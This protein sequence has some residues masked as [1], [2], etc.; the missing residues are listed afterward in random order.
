MK[1][2]RITDPVTCSP[3]DVVEVILETP[4]GLSPS[5]HADDSVSTVLSILSDRVNDTSDVVQERYETPQSPTVNSPSADE[6]ILPSSEEASEHF[7]ATLNFT[8]CPPLA[9]DYFPDFEKQTCHV[10]GNLIAF[11]GECQSNAGKTVHTLR[12]AVLQEQADETTPYRLGVFAYYTSETRIISSKVIEATIPHVLLL[13]EGGELAVVRVSD[14][15]DLKASSVVEMETIALKIAETK[16][17]FKMEKAFSITFD[18]SI[19]PIA[20]DWFPIPGWSFATFHRDFFVT[21]QMH[22]LSSTNRRRATIKFQNEYDVS[23][24]AEMCQYSFCRRLARSCE[25]VET[26]KYVIAKREI[27]VETTTREGKPESESESAFTSMKGLPYVDHHIRVWDNTLWI[28]ILFAPHVMGV[29]RDRVGCVREPLPHLQGVVLFT[30]AELN[31]S[32]L[33]SIASFPDPVPQINA[34]EFHLIKHGQTLSIKS[35]PQHLPPYS[36]A[37]K[38]CLFTNNCTAIILH[39]ATCPKMPIKQAMADPVFVQTTG[40]TVLKFVNEEDEAPL[41]CSVPIN[42]GDGV[43][44][45]ATC[46]RVVDDNPKLAPLLATLKATHKLSSPLQAFWTYAILIRPRGRGDKSALSMT[47]R[48]T[49][50]DPFLRNLEPMSPKRLPTDDPVIGKPFVGTAYGL[51][52]QTSDSKQHVC[53]LKLV[54]QCKDSESVTE[55]IALLPTDSEPDSDGLRYYAALK[56]NSFMPS[57][58][59]SLNNVDQTAENNA[60][61]ASQSPCDAPS[62][63]GLAM[64][65]AADFG[66]EAD[67]VTAEGQAALSRPSMTP[68]SGPLPEVLADGSHD[69]QT[70]ELD[71]P[72]DPIPSPPGFSS[73]LKRPCSAGALP[74]CHIREEPPASRD[75]SAET[76]NRLA[77]AIAAETRKVIKEDIQEVVEKCVRETVTLELTQWQPVTSTQAAPLD[78]TPFAE[79]LKQALD[80]KLAPLAASIKV[81]EKETSSLATKLEHSIQQTFSNSMSTLTQSIGSSL[82]SILA[83]WMSRTI[84]ELMAKNHEEVMARLSDLIRTSLEAAMSPELSGNNKDVIECV[85]HMGEVLKDHLVVS[86]ARQLATLQGETINRVNENLSNGLNL[87]DDKLAHLVRNTG[88]LTELEA[89]LQTF[90]HDTIEGIKSVKSTLVLAKRSIEAVGEQCQNFQDDLK[91]SSKEDSTTGN[92][93]L[94]LMMENMRASLESMQAALRERAPHHEHFS[95]RAGPLYDPA[96]PDLS[97]YSALSRRYVYPPREF[98]DYRLHR[99]FTCHECEQQEALDMPPNWSSGLPMSEYGGPGTTSRRAYPQRFRWPGQAGGTVQPQP[100]SHEMP[101]SMENPLSAITRRKHHSESTKSV[102]VIPSKVRLS[103]VAKCDG[104]HPSCELAQRLLKGLESSRPGLALGQAVKRDYKQSTN[105]FWTLLVS[106]DLQPKTAARS[107]RTPLVLGAA[108]IMAD[109]LANMEFDP[110]REDTGIHTE[111]CYPGGTSDPEQTRREPVPMSLVVSDPQDTIARLKW[112]QRALSVSH[113]SGLLDEEEVAKLKKAIASRITKASVNLKDQKIG[114]PDIVQTLIDT[115]VEMC[116]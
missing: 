98:D 21:W 9:P 82:K 22:E 110:A 43:L 20:I 10:S 39:L 99:P 89:G 26:Q 53:A 50:T 51:A 29:Y 95:H 62:A 34:N 111:F 92:E 94:L 55:T 109:A 97:A 74:P 19:E 61:Q 11:V 41:M 66:P 104:T 59:T 24:F 14:P 31:R 42:V 25:L 72:S 12:L 46:G 27:G 36:K 85:E 112:I 103:D 1:K 77:V 96:F 40:R 113:D 3:A 114:N 49:L 2:H 8:E 16:K 80:G 52:Y 105:G 100:R 67:S 4:I 78:T 60:P 58:G 79:A 57:P 108:K 17:P 13:H 102:S 32:Q 63:T 64:R 86:M 91:K 18:S 56:W 107:F 115:I 90:R 47:L 5:A 88:E 101:S 68:E 37:Y 76:L 35:R 116:S 44:F 83:P 28:F 93:Q 23:N 71:E 73:P 87:I 33:R 48:G 38:L 69:D 84:E 15:S 6:T 54:S 81:A 65:T 30:E 75:P 7:L 45:T 70:M 106:R